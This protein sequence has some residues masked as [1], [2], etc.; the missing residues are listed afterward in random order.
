MEFP[1]PSN[2]GLPIAVDLLNE[3]TE[4]E[5]Q[6]LPIVQNDGNGEI[7]LSTQPEIAVPHIY[8]AKDREVKKVRHSISLVPMD[9]LITS[10]NKRLIDCSWCKGMKL[11]LEEDICKRL[12]SNYISSYSSCDKHDVAL[13]QK[14][15]YLKH[16]R[17]N[18]RDY[19]ERR[20]VQRK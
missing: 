3:P 6:G 10:V 14:I 8:Q 11:V 5:I 9:T 1:P 17:E 19:I 15:Y 4:S 7:A 20:R 12:T 18:C 16:K 13:W 2:N